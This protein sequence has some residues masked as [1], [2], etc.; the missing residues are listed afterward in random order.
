MKKIINILRVIILLYIFAYVIFNIAIY[1]NKNIYKEEYP[2]FSGYNYIKVDN[3]LME[4]YI[5]QNQIIII[6]KQNEFEINDIVLYT[7]RVKYSIKKIANRYN[8]KFLVK[9]ANSDDNEEI[10]ENQVIA[11]VVNMD[12]TLSKILNILLNPVFLIIMFV[13]ASILPEMLFSN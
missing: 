6:K 11:K 13:S 12:K 8:G 5:S 1:I 7:D 10:S 4:P 9:S 3:D 2:T